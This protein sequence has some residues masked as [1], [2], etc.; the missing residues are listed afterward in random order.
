M[1]WSQGERLNLDRFSNFNPMLHS[2]HWSIWTILKQ[3]RW[4]WI[5]YVQRKDGTS[6]TKTAG[7]WIS[8]GKRKRGRPKSNMAQVG[9]QRKTYNNTEHLHVGARKGR[10]R[11]V[12]LEEP[13]FALAVA[14]EM[15]DWMNYQVNCHLCGYLEYFVWTAY[16]KQYACKVN[17]SVF[18]TRLYWLKLLDWQWTGN[19][20]YC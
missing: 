13:P 2:F 4:R 18:G 12:W 19:E 8:E 10:R 7:Y 6:I 16:I 14:M 17:H 11:Q 1:L 15:T 3:P 20:Y 9:Q 5:R